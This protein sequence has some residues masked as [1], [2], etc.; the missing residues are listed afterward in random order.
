[1]QLPNCLW[2][3]VSLSSKW[4]LLW[5]VLWVRFPFI[6]S[7]KHIVKGNIC[8]FYT[9]FL[10]CS[11]FGLSSHYL[12]WYRCPKSCKNRFRGCHCAKSQ[13]RSRQCPCFA[14]D[15]E[16]DPDVCRNCWVR[17]VYEFWCSLSTQKHTKVDALFFFS[18]MLCIVVPSLGWQNT[19][20]LT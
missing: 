4:H 18:F 3:T 10:G 12:I 19:I 13:C 7:N 16:C 8:W 11:G 9:F 20:E 1:M 17:L 15:R 14:A 2:E 6:P 5:E